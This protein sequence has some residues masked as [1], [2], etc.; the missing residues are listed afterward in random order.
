MF[1]SPRL[2]RRP[3]SVLLAATA[4]CAGSLA[5]PVAAT[6]AESQGA[7]IA[8]SGHEIASPQERALEGGVSA[9]DPLNQQAVICWI[10]PTFP[11]ICKQLPH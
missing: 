5:L 3:L 6:A 2:A 4:L 7:V 9:S 1:R 11:W 10:A 8:G